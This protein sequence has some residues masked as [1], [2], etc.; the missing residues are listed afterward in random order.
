[1]RADLHVHST[2]S[3]GTLSPSE[4]VDRAHALG[5]G[6]LAIADHDSVEGLSEAA[7]RCTEL[8]VTLVPEMAI[9][10]GTAVPEVFVM[11]AQPL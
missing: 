3:D 4:L 1:M 2:A 5:V 10:S 7:A 8:G 11:D 6:V 9:A